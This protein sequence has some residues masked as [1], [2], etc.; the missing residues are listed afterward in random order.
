[1]LYYLNTAS[2]RRVVYLLDYQCISIGIYLCATLP[3]RAAA[4]AAINAAQ[5]SLR[6]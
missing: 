5:L 6:I 2:A 1:V 3:H 4:N